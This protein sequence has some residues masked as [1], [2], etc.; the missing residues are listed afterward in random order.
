MEK[1]MKE[2]KLVQVQMTLEQPEDCCGR[3]SENVQY[4]EIQTFNGGGGPY[5]V[6]KTERWA[7][8]SED[9]DR[10]CSRLKEIL[11]SVETGQ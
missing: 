9:I 10:F 5:L 8:D 2:A 11:R 6:L 3:V 1:V 4:M 7:I